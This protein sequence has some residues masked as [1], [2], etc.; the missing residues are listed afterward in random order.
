MVQTALAQLTSLSIS[1]MSKEE[2]HPLASEAHRYGRFS[3]YLSLENNAFEAASDVFGAIEGF[4]SKMTTF[5]CDFLPI[6][7]SHNKTNSPLS[8]C[9]FFLFKVCPP[10]LQRRQH[11]DGPHFK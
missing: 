10:H 3:A 8:V 4:F 2:L 11:Q 7:L 6:C 9:V 1:P 5:V